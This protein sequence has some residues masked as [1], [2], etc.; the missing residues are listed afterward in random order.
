MEQARFMGCHLKCSSCLKLQ[1]GITKLYA[2]QEECLSL[3]AVSDRH[4]LLYSLPTSGGKT[5]V[6]EILMLRELLSKQRDVLFIL[7]FVSIVQEKVRGLSEFGLALDFLVEEYAGSKGQMPPRRRRKNCLYVATIEK[8]N[9]LISS[10]IEDGRIDSVG[11]LVVDELHMLGEGGSR[12]AVLEMS[13]VKVMH[14]SADTQVIGMSA[15]LSNISDLQTFLNADVY[16]NDFR[17]VALQ[18]FVK[19]D[20]NI[21]QVSPGAGSVEERI[22]HSR[23]CVFQYDRAKTRLDPDHVAALVLEVAPLYSCLVFCATKKNCENVAQLICQFMTRE[24]RNA[25]QPERHLLLKAL[26]HASNGHLCPVLRKTVVCGVA[27]HHGGLTTDERKLLEE[28]Y[29][30]ATLC[31]L[32]CTSTLAAGVNLPAKR[33]ILRSP[34]VGMSFL[35]RSQY[36]QMTGRAG[37]AGI[38]SSG[39][40][41]VIT[42]TKD[43]DKLLGLLGGPVERCVSSLLYEEGKGLRRLI[44]TTIGLKLTPS[45]QSV[46][47]FLQRT[48]CHV[49][50]TELDVDLVSLTSTELQTLLDVGL[51][52]L[53]VGQD[54]ALEVTTLGRAT[55]KG[56]V[57]IDRANQLYMDLRIAL[58]SLVVANHLHM[59]YVVTPYDLVSQVKPSWMTYFNQM[60]NLD[61][62]ELKVAALV[63]VSES[64]IAKKASGQ[65]TRKNADEDVVDRFY[66]T[67]ILYSLWKQQSVWDVATKFQLPRGFIQQLLTGA[68][69]FASCV[70][71]FSQELE[72]LWAF[73][74]LLP[75]FVKRLSFCVSMELIPLMEIP[76]VTIVSEHA[77]CYGYP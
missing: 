63:G 53:T 59:L 45:V 51:V 22:N 17:P 14:A 3:P 12:G 77:S 31:V 69:S 28:A 71:H 19:F 64:Y 20:D 43:K 21:Y 62:C 73:H 25:K 70:M 4:N 47:K 8:A 68:A 41:I 52:K 54:D 49:Q 50:S 58:Q 27:Y 72:E 34:Y 7:P 36:K 15:T 67:L 57:D 39:E 38:D 23:V 46:Q 56:S 74:D 61:E 5:L 2:W 75:N 29:S 24:Q 65:R 76:A 32:T 60:N 30:G 40:S 1:R 37:R 13:L 44:L 11:L 6:A 66:L 10:L 55:F 18:E 16:R 48:L 42:Q 35:S 9:S 33:V 26:K